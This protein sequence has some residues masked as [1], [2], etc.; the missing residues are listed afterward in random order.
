MWLLYAGEVVCEILI[1]HIGVGCSKT[2][3]LT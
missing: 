3:T 2:D 1:S